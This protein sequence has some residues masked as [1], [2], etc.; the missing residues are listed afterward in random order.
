MVIPTPPRSPWALNRGRRRRR[1]GGF[2]VIE[3]MTVM[4]I[5]GIL[6][7]LAVSRTKSTID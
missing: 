7:S 1:E 6:T 2:T 5:V 4:V 3:L